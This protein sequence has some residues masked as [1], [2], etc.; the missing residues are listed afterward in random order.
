M[1][2]DEKTKLKLTTENGTFY[3]CSQRCL[4]KFAQE[5]KIAPVSMRDTKLSERSERS[6]PR[7]HSGVLSSDQISQRISNGDE[8]CPSCVA[9]ESK[10]YKNKVLL[11]SSAIL[12]LLTL[13]YFLPF[14]EPFRI[15]FFMY[16]NKI[17]WAAIL[18]LLLGGIIDHLVP[19]E[20]ISKVL[21][22]PKKRTIFYSVLLGFLFSACSHGILA[23]SIQL[24]KKGASSASVVSFL[25]ASPWANFTMTIMLVGF[26]GLKAF[27]IIISAIFIAIVTG[28]IFQYLEGKNLIE[29]NITT[30]P[31]D[32]DF[33]IWED[34]K[35]RIASYN[36]TATA[37]LK[38]IKGVFNGSVA[39]ANMVLWWLLLGMGISSIVGAYIP[40]HIFHK[41][42]GPTALGL[43]VVLVLA[44]IIEVCSEGSA[45]LAFEIFKQTGALGNSFVFLMAGVSTDYT[46]IGL[47]WTNI[48]KKSA[49]WLPVI[50]VPQ[51]IILG[52]LANILFK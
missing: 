15:S 30:L 41:Y 44:T 52:V 24:H 9:P 6:G 31:T 12:F 16:F 51:V 1:Q 11:V 32:E 28:F 42:M 46:E 25:L 20:Y 50:T 34:M 13:S 23:I 40:Q 17:W 35:K 38:E 21:S 36:F 7:I 47:I 18:G 39:L 43:L 4:N 10:F 14:L 26:F 37:M 2:V 3:F 27:Y 19:K 45:P 22:K 48:G 33:S 5:N 49:I 29:K 8:I